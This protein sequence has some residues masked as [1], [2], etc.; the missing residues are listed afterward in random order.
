M[1]VQQQKRSGYYGFCMPTTNIVVT[2]RC[3][4]Y[5]VDDVVSAIFIGIKT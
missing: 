5:N 4:M 1:Q 3:D 2:E